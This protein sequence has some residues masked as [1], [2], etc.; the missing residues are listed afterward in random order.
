MLDSQKKILTVLLI[1][2]LSFSFLSIVKADIILITYH[3]ETNRNG[4][5][6]INRVYPNNETGAY[7]SAIGQTFNVT[8]S[9]PINI[10]DVSFIFYRG[11]NPCGNLTVML[12]NI[13]GSYGT[14]SK[15]IGTPLIMSENITVT[16]ARV[17]SLQWSVDTFH[18]FSDYTLQPNNTYAV[19]LVATTAIFDNTRVVTFGMDNSP[20]HSGNYFYYQNN[21]WTGSS[22]KDSIFWVYGIKYIGTQET[23][24]TE[25]D[26]E[27]YFIIGGILVLLVCLMIMIIII[28]TKK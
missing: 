10:T 23:G 3:D 1:F 18:F 20:A 4:S 2:C 22:S 7:Y 5:L 13:T 15:P 11:S 26:L 8:T 24:Y 12:F 9:F 6:P 25:T 28:K 19:A 21:Q 14:D 27:E 17:P 16:I